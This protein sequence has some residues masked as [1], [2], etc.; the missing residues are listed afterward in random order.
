MTN[1]K[2]NLQDLAH[3]LDNAA[4]A[5]SLV[6]ETMEDISVNLSHVMEDMDNVSAEEDL[7]IYFRQWQREIRILAKLMNHTSN[8]LNAG[9]EEV[10]SLSNQIFD[11]VVRKD[12][13]GK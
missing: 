5:I 4:G 9:N 11:E 6:T 13:K 7:R 8:E 10:K 12:G 3:G 2:M 1:K